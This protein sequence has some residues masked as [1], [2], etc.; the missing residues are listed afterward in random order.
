MVDTSAI[1]RS[2]RCRQPPDWLDVQQRA[3][4]QLSP[5]S[6]Q[7][8]PLLDPTQPL[9]VQLREQVNNR[10]VEVRTLAI[11]SL[12][13]FDDFDPFDRCDQLRRL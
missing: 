7:L 13:Q 1:S 11:R 6:K 3:A 8:E 9:I 4:D 5:R 10:L 12:S 2:S